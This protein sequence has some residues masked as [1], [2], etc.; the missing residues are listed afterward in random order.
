MLISMACLCLAGK[1]ADVPKRTNDIIRASVKFMG[2]NDALILCTPDWMEGMVR[3]L[4]KAERSLLYLLGFRFED[5]PS[6]AVVIKILSED[7][8]VKL[9]I[10]TTS[11]SN[12]DPELKMKI[13]NIAYQFALSSSKVPLT[14]QFSQQAIGAVCVWLAMKMLVLDT[15]SMRE[16]EAGNPWYS[17]YGLENNDVK[18]IADIIS[19]C[20]KSERLYAMKLKSGEKMDLS[21]CNPD[22]HDSVDNKLENVENSNGNIG[23]DNSFHRNHQPVQEA[24]GQQG[25]FSG[26]NADFHR[27][28]TTEKK[29]SPIPHQHDTAVEELEELFG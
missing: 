2:G 8:S 6:P 7:E 25:S 14:L 1:V 22:E 26:P 11:K 19:D 17:K 27:E 10:E 13:S 28:T 24:S 23:E 3:T 21:S 9:L 20:V 4:V 5:I 15:A 29:V 16:A 12:L 18:K